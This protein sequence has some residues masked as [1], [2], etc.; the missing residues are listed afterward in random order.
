MKEN[1]DVNA[2]PLVGITLC[3]YN[4]FSLRTWGKPKHFDDLRLYVPMVKYL[5]DDLNANVFLLPHVYR[6]NP[7]TYAGELINGPDYDICLNL[8][9]MVDGNKYK[10]RLKLVEGKYTPSEAKG[11]IGQ[12][13]MYISGRLHAGVAA[14]SQA[15]PTV[16]LAYGHKHR[17]FASLLYQQKYVYEGKDTEELVSIVED[18]WKNREEITKVLKDRMTRIRE[19]VHLNFEIVK[20]IV[21]L[22]EKDRNHMP[23]EL[24]YAWVKRGE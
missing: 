3:G 17:G 22:P 14:L 11:I 12:C 18:A 13:D 9:K 6:T 15:I 7:Y 8:F 2:R 23:K 10:G 4:L 19:L 24:S 21:G 1:V 20:E 16:L 5:L